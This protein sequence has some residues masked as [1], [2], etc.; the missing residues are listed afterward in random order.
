MEL[1]NFTEQSKLCLQEVEKLARSYGHQ[2]LYPEHLLMQILKESSGIVTKMIALV[3]GDKNKIKALTVKALNLIPKVVG[4]DNIYIDQSLQKT[5][6]KA[7][8]LASKNGERGRLVDPLVANKPF[9]TCATDGGYR[10]LI[11]MTNCPNLRHV[12]HSTVKLYFGRY[13]ALSVNFVG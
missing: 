7:T 1:E 2:R 6:S 11:P 9:A 5:F 13:Y 10:G 8:E 12:R 3:D 4:E